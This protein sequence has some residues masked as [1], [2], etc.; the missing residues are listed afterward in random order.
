MFKGVELP[1][2]KSVPTNEF[3]LGLGAFNDM[4]TTVIRYHDVQVRK[5]PAP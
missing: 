3:Y 1:R 2:D 4:N 5:L